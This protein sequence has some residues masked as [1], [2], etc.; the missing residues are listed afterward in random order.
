VFGL[1]ARGTSELI[2]EAGGTR[3][4]IRYETTWEYP[5]L[6]RLLEKAILR[7]ATLRRELQNLKALAERE[8]RSGPSD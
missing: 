8:S 2:P 5:R 6:G 3:L 4:A 1:R 7:P